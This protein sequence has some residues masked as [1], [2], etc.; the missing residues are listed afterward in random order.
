MMP[1]AGTIWI[2][3]VGCELKIARIKRCQQMAFGADHPAWERRDRHT[4]G[5]SRTERCLCSSVAGRRRK[6][7]CHL[8]SKHGLNGRKQA[9]F[10]NLFRSCEIGRASCRERVESTECARGV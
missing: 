3:R 6:Q 4:N 10:E 5:G 2:I 7:L 1:V 8:R 9:F